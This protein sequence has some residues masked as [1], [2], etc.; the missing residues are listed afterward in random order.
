M[1]R[2]AAVLCSA[3]LLT[4]ILAS[5]GASDTAD[6]TT[7][8][9]NESSVELTKSGR[10]IEYA[11]EDFSADYYNADELEDFVK[12]QIDAYEENNKGRIK[13]KRERVRKGTARLT[14]RYNSVDTYAAF[15]GVECFSGTVDEAKEA[16]YDFSMNFILAQEEEVVEEEVTVDGEETV[17]ETLLSGQITVPGKTVAGDDSLKVLIIET[18]MDVTV[19]GEVQ[20]FYS[21]NGTVS[22]KKEDTVQVRVD[23]E[24]ANVEN[25]VYVLYKK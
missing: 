1:K 18:D 25:L 14:L 5:C 19:P 2:V 11:I 10:V 16:G 23:E 12:E 6:E 9:E 4:C 17:S 15:N 13:V 20:Y 8:T 7:V 24:F 22:I 3:V 21:T